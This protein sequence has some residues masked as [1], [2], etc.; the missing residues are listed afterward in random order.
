MAHRLLEHGDLSQYDL[1]SLT[2]F[3]LASAPSSPAFKQ[4]LRE[5]VPFA[6]ALVD[7]Y[8]MT[9]TCAVASP[10]DLAQWPGTLGRPIVTVQI[11]ARDPLGVP[12]PEGQE[13]E[14]YVRSPF[15]MLGYWGDEA[16]TAATLHEDR[17]LATGDL[18]MLED[19][20]LRLTSR[21]SDLVL[22]GGE[23]VYPAEV[24]AVLAEH[25]AVRECIVLGKPHADLGE[26]VAAVVVL[27]DDAAVTAQD[28][29]AWT[30]EQLAYYKVP[31]SWRLQSQPLPRNATGKVA[32]RDVPALT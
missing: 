8:G 27:E 22:R 15:N 17:W 20:R 31:S 30:A 24:E 14:I 2:S 4:R 32:R 1:S 7:S 29:Q 3:A 23:N 9:E 12:L 21:R 10:M 5:K 11:E 13:G 18:G 19:G 25:P 16:A 6:A 28:L 26:E